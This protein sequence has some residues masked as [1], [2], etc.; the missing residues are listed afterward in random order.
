MIIKIILR[1]FILIII[2][3]SVSARQ[4]DPVTDSIFYNNISRWFSAWELISEDIYHLKT[5]EPVDFIF[6]D[7]TYV[8]STSSITVSKGEFLEGPNLLDQNLVWKRAMH[9]DTITLP[10][11]SRVPVGLMAFASDLE[12]EK[13]KSFFVMPLPQFWT[14]AGVMSKELGF[15]NLLTGVFLHEF[16]HSQQM[17]NFGKKISEFE[18]NN[19]LGIEI[20]DDLIQEIFEKD[21]LHNLMFEREVN[22]FY[23]AVTEEDQAIKK[24]LIKKGIDSF[25]KRQNKYF[26]GKYENLKQIEELFLT[27]EGLGQFTMYSW[28]IHKDGPHLPAEIAISG[29]RRGRNR[30]SQDEGFALFLLLDQ[31]AEPGKWAKFM[32]G[33][34]MESIINL[35]EQEL[36]KK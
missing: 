1:F 15:E 27:M 33:K 10:D 7:T 35:L 25:R 6:F 16:S 34:K 23:D 17:Q 22:T 13:E 2:S 32:F 26:T 28:L 14:K 24:S 31:L 21:S 19:D 29:V 3:S 20:S 5:H 8:Y 30:W 36:N 11:H 12:G 4:T 18:S 9:N